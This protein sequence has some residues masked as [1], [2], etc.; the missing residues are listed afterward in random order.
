MFSD[1][2]KESFQDGSAFY[3]DMWPLSPLFLAVVSP[4][5]A[6]TVTQTNPKISARKPDLLHKLFKPLAGGPN[7]FHMPEA[8]WKPWRATFSNCFSNEHFMYLIPGI[9]EQTLIY[10]DTLRRHAQTS[11]TFFLDT[12]AIRFTMDIIGKTVL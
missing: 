8:E 6:T 5:T 10:C 11:D 12:T 7:L 2:Y 4:T 9:V 3:L 1:I